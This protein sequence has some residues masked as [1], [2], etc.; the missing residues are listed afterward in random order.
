MNELIELNEK[1]LAAVFTAQGDIDGLLGDIETRAR[2]IVPD[3]GTAKGRKEIASMAHAVSRTK[4]ALDEAGRNLVAGWKQQAKVVDDQ[5]KKIRDRL[6]VLRDEV[7][8]PL[9]DWEQAEKDRVAAIHEGLADIRKS[10][11]ESVGSVQAAYRIERLEAV[12]IDDFAEFAAE[13]AMARDSAI[14]E[15]KAALV[16]A[17]D[18]EEK[19]A[20]AERAAK[21][22]AERIQR[23][24]EERIAREAADRARIEA[25]EKARKEREAEAARIEAAARAAAE[26]AAAEKVEAERRIREAEERAAQ[27][28]REARDKVEREEAE[29]QRVLDGQREAEARRAADEAHREQINQAAGLALM[30]MVGLGEKQASAVVSAIAGGQVPNVAIRY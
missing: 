13:A 18:R 27:A 20:E 15:W 4:T 8:Q 10:P 28:E 23:E 14:R 26:K 5:R 29:R 7:R 21:A 11:D 19:A 12:K 24:R 1:S 30:M 16:I 2:A 17:K 6:D 3:L 9:T 25:E 22:E